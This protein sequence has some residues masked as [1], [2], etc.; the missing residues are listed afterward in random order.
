M[1]RWDLTQEC[2]VGSAYKS[3][4]MKY[5]LI[6]DKNH[7]DTEK[8]Y[9]RIHQPFMRKTPNELGTE[10]TAFTL[11]ENI[12]KKTPQLTLKLTLKD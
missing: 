3:Q 8:P 4:S 9:N 2:T 10:G 12:Y 5:I 11:L 1:I 6:M 7:I